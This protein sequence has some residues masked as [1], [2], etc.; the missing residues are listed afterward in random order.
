MLAVDYKALSMVI[1]IGPIKLEPPIG[2][3]IKETH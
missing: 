1:S 2:D 3:F